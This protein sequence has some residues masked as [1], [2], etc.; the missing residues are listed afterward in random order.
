MSDSSHTGLKWVMRAG[1]GARGLI[2]TTVGLLALLAAFTTT[3]AEGTQDALVTL[4]AQPFG[5]LALWVIGL[6]LI[7]YM[8]WRIVAGIAD[9]EDHGADAKGLISR[10]GQVV[11]GLL[12][13]GVG[14]SVL[15]LARGG[16]DG[17]A[18]GTASWTAYL[19]SMPMGQY[20][21]AAGALVL[22]GAGGYYA[23]KGWTGKYRAHLQSTAFTERVNPALKAGLIIYGL[24]L[25]LIA[26][27]FGVAALNADPSQAGGLGKA[28]GQLRAMAFGRVLLGIAGAGLLAFAGYN[29]VEAAYRFVPR[30]SGPDVKT[31]AKA[32]A[33]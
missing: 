11:T 7:A 29:F 3:Q 9:V 18:D 28:L 30:I 21:V 2:Y 22:A 17:S 4:R 31:L 13:A 33:S 32:A 12:H 15:S 6:G 27:S 26:L 5:R 23:Y 16:G 14:L 8:V 10:A 25:A 24:L 19:M 20:I 1:Y